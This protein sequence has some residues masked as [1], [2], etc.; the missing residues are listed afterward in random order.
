MKRIHRV[1]VES[2]ETFVY[3]CQV[4]RSAVKWDQCGRQLVGSVVV[5]EADPLPLNTG[6]ELCL[7]SEDVTEELIESGKRRI[8]LDLDKAAG[9][10]L[11]DYIG[12]PTPEEVAEALM[13]KPVD[14][15][16]H[17]DWA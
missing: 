4:K 15:L 14:I 17:E 2:G 12:R 3:A 16:T 9:R 13:A 6:L 1:K 7:S 10:H 8:L 5:G 11:A